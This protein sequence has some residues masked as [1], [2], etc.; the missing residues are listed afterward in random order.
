MIRVRN[1]SFTHPGNIPALRNI[2]LD[3]SPG[4]RLALIGPNGSGKTT[5]A[6]CFNGL[7]RPQTGQ[8]DVDELSAYPPGDLF[9]IRKRIGMVFQNPDD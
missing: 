5:L 2:N 4:E 3:I 9:E 7:E 6:R 8:I 1:L